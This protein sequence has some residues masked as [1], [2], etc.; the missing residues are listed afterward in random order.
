MKSKM[1]FIGIMLVVFLLVLAKAPGQAKEPQQPGLLGD[2][3][4]WDE[5][6]L[7]TN[8]RLVKP[9]EPL[10]SATQIISWEYDQIRPRVAYSNQADRYLVV[11]EDHHWG[12]GDDWDIYGRFIGS[13]GVPLGSHFGI[14][15]E[16]AQ[17]R[18]APAVAYNSTS[19]EF[20][21]VWEY[22]FSPSDHDIYAQRISSDGNLIGSEI[23]VIADASFDEYNEEIR[24]IAKKIV[25][26]EY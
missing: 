11:W 20:L 22:E 5:A 14:S 7:R 4:A 6:L 8:D 1:S 9:S 2:T 10:E 21:V 16:G 3:R 19:G 15:W 17:H 23:T 12:F 24:L 13:D 26:M 18:L 25:K